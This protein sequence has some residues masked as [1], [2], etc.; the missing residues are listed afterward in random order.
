MI[1][2][3]GGRGTSIT[4]SRRNC[5]I[6]QNQMFF[7]QSNKLRVVEKLLRHITGKS[8]HSGITVTGKDELI[9]FFCILRSLSPIGRPG[10]GSIIRDRRRCIGTA[11][12]HRQIHT[13]KCIDS[14]GIGAFPESQR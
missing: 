13:A 5:F 9:V 12:F 10:T 11:V 4:F 6:K 2:Q 1:Q 14:K 7:C 3:S 8:A